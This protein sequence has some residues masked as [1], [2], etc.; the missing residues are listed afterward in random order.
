MPRKHPKTLGPTG[1]PELLRHL[2]F[3]TSGFKVANASEDSRNWLTPDGDRV[4][5]QIT[6]GKPHYPDTDSLDLLKGAFAPPRENSPIAN[7]E[8][9]LVPAAGQT[10][11]WI[12]DRMTRKMMGNMC[13]IGSV[14]L[15][16]Q[17]GV[18]SIT[19]FCDLASP[20]A[21]QRVRAVLT[22]IV[23]TLQCDLAKIWRP[24]TLPV[25][26]KGEQSSPTN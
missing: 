24:Y 6:K 17:E 5:Y 7:E 20:C 1:D 9:R 10:A 3:D 13:L 14:Q 12:V 26:T 25:I 8:F 2:S 11:I 18:A 4:G 15:P 22:R 16:F 19:V 23:D 21:S